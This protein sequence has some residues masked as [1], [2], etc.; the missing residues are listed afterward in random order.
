M[1]Y[2]KT[3]QLDGHTQQPVIAISGLS[4]S[5][6]HQRTHAAGFEDHIDK[7]FDDARLLAAVGAV[8][9]RRSA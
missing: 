9:G 8:M 1:H 6:D 5:A 3:T 7:P 2:H 4:S